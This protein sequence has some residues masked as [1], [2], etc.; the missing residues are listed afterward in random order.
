IN[1]NPNNNFKA[2]VEDFFDGLELYDDKYNNHNYKDFFYVSV[3]NFLENKNEY[4]ASEIYRLFFEIYQITHDEPNLMLELVETLK[5]YEENM[6]DLIEKQRDYYIHS[7]N[8]FLLGLAIYSQNKN[9]KNAFL[10]ANKNKYYN[11]HYKTKNEEF[12]YRWGIAALLHNIGYP[13]EIFGKR[14]KTF[15][16][17]GVNSVSNLNV[18]FSFKNFDNFNTITKIDP[19]FP[20]S[21]RDSYKET[22]FIDLFKPLDILA[23]RISIA[24]NDINL[25]DIKKNLDNFVKKMIDNGSI[26]P[27]FYS[28]ILVTSYYGY[29]VQKYGKKSEFFFFP[30]VDSASAIL[31]HNYY[32]NVLMSKRGNLKVNEHP[33]AY[34]LILCNELQEWN[35]PLFGIEDKK[36]YSA[37]E[38]KIEINNEHIAID[39][40]IKNGTLSS[41]AGMEKSEFLDDVLDINNIFKKGLLVNTHIKDK[42]EKS[43]INTS[44]DLNTPR[45][46]ISNI[47][48]LARSIHEIYSVSLEKQEQ[49]ETFDDLPKD[50]KYSYFRQASSIPNKLNMLGYEIVPRSDKRKIKKFTDEEI[51]KLAIIEHDEWVKERINSGW[52]Y[53]PH[54]NIVNKKNPYIVPW[55]ELKDD[56]M[57]YDRKAVK[58]IPKILNSVGMKVVEKKLS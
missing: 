20:D 52:V 51:E 14:M 11:Y 27:D 22:N 10:L 34:L 2:Y 47:E 30:I 19:H 9:Y 45:Q 35:R 17:E 55:E 3:M 40:V 38:L 37:N 25:L 13:L 42:I 33:I 54:K 57:E 26:D 39:Y 1:K 32:S 8:V 44:I 29:L 24:F 41:R 28:A 49:F 18:A 5:K 36:E 48:K 7:V 4:N 43:L 31:L 50:M 16:N 58:N 23:H 12:F 6:G 46:T 53:S 56:V 15:M 21:Y